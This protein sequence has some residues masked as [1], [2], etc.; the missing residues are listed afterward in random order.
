MIIYYNILSNGAVE[1]RKRNAGFILV[2]KTTRKTWADGRTVLKYILQEQT[3]GYGLES[4]GSGQTDTSGK[5][6]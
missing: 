6:L 4:S 5:L 1:R 2:G 3:W